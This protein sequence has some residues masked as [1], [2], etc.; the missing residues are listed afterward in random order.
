MLCVLL[1]AAALTLW[2]FLAGGGGG[3]REGAA[4]VPSSSPTPSI[5]PG[6][7]RS[8][9]AIDNPPG[10]GSHDSGKP[11]PGKSSSPGGTSGGDSDDTDQ[12]LGPDDS[13]WVPSA[14]DE[15]NGG[16]NGGGST[17]GGATG[18]G[19][20]GK[21]GSGGASGSSGRPDP[22]TVQTLKPC[23]ADDVTLRLIPE[24]PGKGE[25]FGPDDLARFRLKVTNAGGTDC[26]VDTTPKVTV[27]SPDGTKRVWSSKDCPDESFPLLLGVRADATTATVFQWAKVRASEKSCDA[28]TLQHAAAGDYLMTVQVPGLG[29]AE[30][31]FTLKKS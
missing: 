28:D 26:K 16:G 3:K 18:G 12:H 2:A 13:G 22:A 29:K 10:G 23:S 19:S 21:T 9:P 8:G 24:K 6:P 20:G 4:G 25:T 11:A 5:T 17:S 15:G 7:S 30:H 1:L 14:P 31:D 27:T